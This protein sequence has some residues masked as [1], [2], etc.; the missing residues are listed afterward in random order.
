[1]SCDH[2]TCTDIVQNYDEKWL[3]EHPEIESDF[4]QKL[5]SLFSSLDEENIPYSQY[6]RYKSAA[7]SSNVLQKRIAKWYGTSVNGFMP[8]YRVAGSMDDSPYSLDEKS[9]QGF[10]ATETPSFLKEFIHS[11]DPDLNHC[12]VTKYRDKSDS[13]GPHQDKNIENTIKN[14]ILFL[15]AQ[16]VFNGIIQT[17]DYFLH[18]W[19]KFPNIPF[20]QNL[21]TVY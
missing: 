15:N 12:V 2:M 17:S 20:M 3:E 11:I 4:V 21:C 9:V 7:S 14:L 13:I 5:R 8:L 6:A 19:Q 16:I 10:Q 18:T 1:M